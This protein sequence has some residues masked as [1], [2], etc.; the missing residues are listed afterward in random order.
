MAKVE[1]QP[2]EQV[3]KQG[4]VPYLKGRF[5]LVQGGGYLTDR[6]FVHT[7]EMRGIAVGG[8][9]GALIKGKVDIEIWLDSISRISRD[10][11]GRNDAVL[12]IETVDGE[13]YRLLPDFDEWLQA[14]GS[15]LAAHRGIDLA[16]TGPNQWSVQR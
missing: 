1:L 16:Q 6:R 4:A 10:K 13:E 2:G 11:H 8:L 14:F 9:V 12:K 7:N 15:T 3:L 5:N